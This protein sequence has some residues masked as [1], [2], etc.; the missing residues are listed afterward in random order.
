[1]RQLP[2]KM[3]KVAITL[4]V[5]FKRGRDC[6]LRLMDFIDPLKKI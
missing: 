5:A 3:R 4:V 2:I 1:M 6:L